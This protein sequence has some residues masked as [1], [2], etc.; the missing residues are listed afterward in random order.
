MPEKSSCTHLQEAAAVCRPATDWPAV[1]IARLAGFPRIHCCLVRKINHPNVAGYT[2][3]DCCLKDLHLWLS[4]MPRSSLG[5]LRPGRCS[6]SRQCIG[7]TA[8]QKRGLASALRA[9]T[10]QVFRDRHLA[11]VASRRGTLAHDPAGPREEKG[12]NKALSFCLSNP[13]SLSPSDLAQSTCPARL[14]RHLPISVRTTRLQLQSGTL[15][16][17]DAFLQAQTLIVKPPQL[18]AIREN[19]PLTTP[20]VAEPWERQAHSGCRSVDTEGV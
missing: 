2:H 16:T 15:D 1:E 11:Q 10:A 20:V 9:S 6:F 13:L 17:Q 12:G 3:A 14:S 18:A 8:L 5:N 19:P 4:T 7:E